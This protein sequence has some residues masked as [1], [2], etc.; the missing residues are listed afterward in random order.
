MASDGGMNTGNT[1][2]GP[3]ELRQAFEHFQAMS[4]QLIGAYRQIEGRVAQ[5][6]SE[7]EHSRSDRLL[8]LAE[9]ERLANRLENLLQALPAGVLVLDG[10]GRVREFNPAA[11]ALLGPVSGGELWRDVV[12][13][14]FAPRWD[15]GHDISLKD[16]RRVNLS[17]EAL[18]GEPGQIVLLNN[19]TETR[20]LQEQLAQHRRLAA[21]GE[22]AAGLAHQ[23]RT[24]LTSAILYLSNLRR[25]QL[26]EGLRA[27][28]SEQA[29]ARLKHL[30]RLVADMLLFARSGAFDAVDLEVAALLADLRPGAGAVQVPEGFAVTLV[31]AS[32]AARIRGNRDALLSACANLI[33]NAEQA[34]EGR[35][36]MTITARQLAGMV[37]L[38]F[39]D[40][41]PGVPAAIRDSIFEP[42]FTTRSRGSGLGLAVCQAVIEAHGG[43][44][45]LDDAQPGAGSTFRIRL[46]VTAA[47]DVSMV[48]AEEPDSGRDS[49]L[50]VPRAA[51]ASASTGGVAPV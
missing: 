19:V 48:E 16:G 21:M 41:G 13:R 10:E 30:E 42:F 36:A 35:G 6:T 14:A 2:T 34:A 24:P 43:Q 47:P 1:Q 51:A 5:L 50:G 29:L 4:A 11:A 46:P 3:A 33:E 26:D 40:D 17:T 49:R 39:C 31:D 20:E 18:G 32:G 38:E 44:I 7:L 8:Q 9:K 37:E 28:F 12:A 23:I 25:G 22:M 45:D 15:D 27:R